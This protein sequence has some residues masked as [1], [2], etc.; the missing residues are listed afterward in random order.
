MSKTVEVRVT[1]WDYDRGE[2][3]SSINVGGSGQVEAEDF[4]TGELTPQTVS[5]LAVHSFAQALMRFDKEAKK[6]TA[7]LEPLPS[8]SEVS[9]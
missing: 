7:E 9:H 1:I 4:N 3:N 5:G 2:G 8:T 6:E